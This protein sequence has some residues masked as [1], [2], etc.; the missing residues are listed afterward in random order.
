MKTHWQVIKSPT[1]KLWVL[2]SKS[3]LEDGTCTGWCTFQSFKTRK[4]AV[5]IGMFMRE[6]G[7]PISWEGGP[8][9]MGIALV[10]SC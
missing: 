5:Q 4:L 1:K 10:H 6:K 7:D 9:R 3:Y 2:Q 8:I